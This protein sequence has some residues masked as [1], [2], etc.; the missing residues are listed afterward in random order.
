MISFYGTP[1]MTLSWW[2]RLGHTLW[3]CGL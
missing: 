2:Q 3:W 1:D